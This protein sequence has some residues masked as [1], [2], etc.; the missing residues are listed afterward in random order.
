MPPVLKPL[1]PRD[2]S[3]VTGI[4]LAKDN[5]LYAV[6]IAGVVYRIPVGGGPVVLAT[7]GGDHFDDM[8]VSRPATSSCWMA[9]SALFT[10]SRQRVSRLFSLTMRSAFG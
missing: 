6:N 7:L 9:G 8:A 3:G 1:S 5:T 4:A 2:S 10:K